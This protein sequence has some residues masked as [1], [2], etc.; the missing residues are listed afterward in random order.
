MRKVMS[1]TRSSGT[2]AARR[3]KR[4]R[5]RARRLFHV[6]VAVSWSPVSGDMYGGAAAFWVYLL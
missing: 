1:G 3:A 6:A 2:A 4:L 5:A